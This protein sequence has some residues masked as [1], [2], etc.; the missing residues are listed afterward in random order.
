VTGSVSNK[1]NVKPSANAVTHTKMAA[2]ASALAGALTAGLTTGI[3]AGDSQ[4]D[5]GVGTGMGI[6]AALTGAVTAKA[7]A[8]YVT[9]SSGLPATELSLT[10]LSARLGMAVSAPAPGIDIKPGMITIGF[11]LGAQIMITPTGVTVDGKAVTLK[12]NALM[13]GTPTASTVV[14]GKTIQMGTPTSVVKING[15]AITNTAT[16]NTSL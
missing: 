5:A 16:A 6:A 10:P 7:I 3:L 15:S 4:G 11:G 14:A 13:L 12:G 8:D 2:G 1:F 9:H